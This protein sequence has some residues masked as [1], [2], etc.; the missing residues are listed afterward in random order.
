MSDEELLDYLFAEQTEDLDN[1]PLPG[2][3]PYLSETGVVFLYT[4]YEIAPYSSGI[5][6]FEIPFADIHPFLTPEAQELIP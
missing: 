6:T 4:Q 5:I 3:A 1:L 2:N